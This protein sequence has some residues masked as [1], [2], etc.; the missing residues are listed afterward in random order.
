MGLDFSPHI[1]R[2]EAKKTL[3]LCEKG[4][5]RHL[6]ELVGSHGLMIAAVPRFL[7]VTMFMGHFVLTGVAVCHSVRKQQTPAF[8]STLGFPKA[9]QENLRTD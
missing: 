9:G 2:D 3:V 4:A 7:A 1:P 6:V 8:L 5:W